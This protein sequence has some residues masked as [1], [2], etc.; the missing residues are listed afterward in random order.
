MRAEPARS[1]P[2]APGRFARP[3]ALTFA[4]WV[5][6]AA[7]LLWSLQTAELS[8]SRLLNGL[9]QMAR[10]LGEMMPPATSRLENIAE[11]LLDTFRMA[12][13]GTLFGVLLS[14]PLAV[15]AARGLSPARPVYYLAR[16]LITF[17]RTVPD[18]VW[19]IFFVVTVGLGPFAGVLTLTVDTMGY[20][21]RFFAEAMEEVD[22]GPQE[23][24]RTAGAGRTGVII[25]AVIPSALPSMIASSLFALEQAT[26]SSVILGLVGAGGIGIE[27][28]ASMDLFEYDQAA[29]IIIAIFILVAGVERVSSAL[30]A[31]LI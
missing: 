4:L 2:P 22:T 3:S 29:T 7:L 25:G 23:A 31:R 28:K 19:A 8:L 5:G 17:F 30:R 11:T 24:L 10:L 15:A 16:A 26:R 9:P 14:L 20:C 21:G 27:L 1:G 18:L 12:L 6:A 13:V